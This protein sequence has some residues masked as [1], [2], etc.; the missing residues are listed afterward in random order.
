VTYEEPTERKDQWT[1]AFIASMHKSA[2]LRAP[3][4]ARTIGL[5][6]VKRVLD[7]GGGSG[8]YSIAFARANSELHSEILDLPS[9]IPIAQKHIDAANLSD[10][11]STRSGDLRKDN[12]GS[13]YDLILLSSI[14]H[15]NSPEENLVLLQKAFKA[16]N[17]G[18]RIIIQDFMMDQDKTKPLSGALF[19]LNM[20]VA[21]R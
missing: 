10:R 1:G 14:C 6:G 16:L 21:Y 19:S 5:D 11:I 2:S 13:G 4:V 12:L 18:G 15:M 20:L 8:A 9:V 17:Q 3:Q 7:V